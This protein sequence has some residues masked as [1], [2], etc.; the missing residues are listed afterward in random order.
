MVDAAVVLV[1]L[2]TALAVFVVAVQAAINQRPFQEFTERR[3]RSRESAS[4]GGG[5]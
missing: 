3:A 2:I 5:R 4:V 1:C